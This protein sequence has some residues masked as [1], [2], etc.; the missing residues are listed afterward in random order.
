M[1]I[2]AW[3]KAENMEMCESLENLW[4]MSDRV[5]VYREDRDYGLKIRKAVAET[6]NGIAHKLYDPTIEVC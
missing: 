5:V 6:L 3:A 1:K 4:K 2:P